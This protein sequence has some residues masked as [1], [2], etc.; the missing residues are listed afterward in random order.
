MHFTGIEEL[1][2][3]MLV[4]CMLRSAVRCLRNPR[5]AVAS[6]VSTTRHCTMTCRFG[7]LVVKKC[8]LRVDP[9]KPELNSICYLLAL[10]AHHFFHVSRIRVKSLTFR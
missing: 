2:D 5:S 7:F 3:A 9:L 6:R 8:A 10:L 1:Y 4:D